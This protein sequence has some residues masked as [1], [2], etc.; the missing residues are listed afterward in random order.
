MLPRVMEVYPRIEQV[1]EAAV[2]GV[3]EMTAAVPSESGLHPDMVKFVRR[4]SEILTPLKGYEDDRGFVTRALKVRT[5]FKRELTEVFEGKRKFQ[6]WYDG[7]RTG[8]GMRE[9]QMDKVMY[10]ALD[11][12]SSPEAIEMRMAYEDKIRGGVLGV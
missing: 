9:D 7:T 5:Q 1:R 12:L 10:D 2:E 8:L 11:G 6:E 3:H 4:V